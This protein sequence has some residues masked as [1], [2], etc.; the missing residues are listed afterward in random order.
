[1]FNNLGLFFLL[2]DHCIYLDPEST[3]MLENII[4]SVLFKR[5]SLL[6][7][8]NALVFFALIET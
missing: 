8:Q 7:A 4:L 1:M 6:E 5:K 2:F 3:N